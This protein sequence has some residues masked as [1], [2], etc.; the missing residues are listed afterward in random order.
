VGREGFTVRYS[1]GIRVGFIVGIMG[2]LVGIDEVGTEVGEIAT[3][4]LADGWE[5][6]EDGW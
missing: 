1:D 6:F 3:V 2:C 5:G 4:G